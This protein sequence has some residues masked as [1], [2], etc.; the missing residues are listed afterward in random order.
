[1]PEYRNDKL[2]EF[3]EDKELDEFTAAYIEAAY[4]TDTGDTDQ[5]TG[6]EELSAEDL[7]T[8]IEEC[9][10]FQEANKAILESLYEEDGDHIKAI[11]GAEQAGHDFWLTRNG[12]GAGFWDR[13]LGKRGDQL[14]EAAQDCGGRMLMAGDGD[15]IH[16]ESC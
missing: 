15:T 8:I 9:K 1:M 10:E 2:D 3:L 16:Y 11:Y 6:E 12:H 5:P 4:W 14:S 13:G 7:A